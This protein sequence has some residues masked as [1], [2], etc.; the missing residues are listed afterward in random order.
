M[1]IYKISATGLSINYMPQYVAEKLGYFRDVDIEVE[2]S[3]PSSWTKVLKDINSGTHHAVCGGIWVPSMYISHGVQE[4]LAFAKISSRCPYKL[5]SREYREN[6]MW[7]D[8]ENKTVLIPCDGG[9]SAY[10]YLVGRLKDEGVDISKIRFIHD[11]VEEMLSECFSLGTM[12]DFIFTTPV[13]ADNLSD[14]KKGYI[15]SE[16]ARTGGEVPWSVYYSTIDVARGQ[17]NLNGRFSI[18]IQRGLEWMNAHKGD[19]CRDILK[20]NWPQMDTN[21][22]VA[23]I[24]R[25]IEDGMWANTIEIGVTEYEN[26]ARY[27]V[28]AGIIDKPLPYDKI[29][30]TS[31]LRFVKNELNL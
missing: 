12:G 17:D 18:A 23:T 7:K 9:A 10:I 5:V 4:Y 31:T 8:L 24:D 27:Q 22:A 3:V 14:A 16:M 21:T 11:F 19:D 20:N 13:T 6:F 1:D 28:D 2:T 26:Y 15:V 25:F 30:D 29:V